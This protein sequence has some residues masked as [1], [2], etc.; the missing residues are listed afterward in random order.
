[1]LQ[2]LRTQP[3]DGTTAG[4]AREIMDRQLQHLVRLVDDLLDVSRIMR[5]RIELR[6]ERIEL[7]QIVE[8][9]V[10][11]AQ[12]VMDARG[13]CL[14][15]ELPAE[16]IWLEAD[17]VRLAQVI[18]NLLN[19]A[20]KFS[21]PASLIKLIAS[22]EA[23]QVAVRVK[24]TGVGI[25]P[26]MLPNL[27][28]PFMQAERSISRSQG[29]LGIGL[30]LVRRLVDLHNG[31]V[32]AASDGIGKGSEFVVRLPTLQEQAEDVT[33]AETPGITGQ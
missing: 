25:A 28:E 33:A 10:E 26:E 9:A 4:K 7:R 30:A 6:K 13:Q 15:V 29:G 31:T 19:N 27:F 21:E 14:H 22:R 1:S 23:E 2:L 20:S 17:C 12:P 5:G 24:D 16:P 18:A 32:T 8:R 3:A 11:T